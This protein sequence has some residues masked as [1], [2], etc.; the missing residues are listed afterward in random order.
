MHA[1]EAAIEWL[2]DG[3]SADV[4]GRRFSGRTTFMRGIRSQLED[5]GWR[6]LWVS[7]NAF[8]QNSPL[9]SLELSGVITGT[10]RGRSALHSAVAG[11][12]G[13]ARPE[14]FVVL[15]DDWDSLDDASWGVLTAAQEQVGFPIVR[16]TLRR[17][18]LASS[19]TGIHFEQSPRTFVVDLRPMTIDELERVLVTH[20]E[21]PIDNATASRIL[22]K[23][24]GVVGLAL[25]IVD[26]ARAEGTLRQ[27]AGLW[28]AEA[29]LWSDS[30]T[31]IAE[32]YIAGISEAEL[33]VLET[34]ALVGE[35]DVAEARATL[36]WRAVES[37]ED[38]AL[39]RLYSIGSR[40]LVSVVP[41]LVMELLRNQTHCARRD[42]V[43]QDILKDGILDGGTGTERSMAGRTQG[44]EQPDALFVR[45]FDEHARGRRTT[46]RARWLADP[47]PATAVPFLQVLNDQ[48]ADPDE[49][50]L[51]FAGTD[52]AD[53]DDESRAQFAIQRAW[54]TAGIDGDLDAALTELASARGGLGRY[55]RLVDAARVDIES[56][57]RGI[58][59]DAESLLAIDDDA[60][61][62]PS[63]RDKISESRLATFFSLGQFEKARTA[64]QFLS[65]TPLGGSVY[66]PGFL[67]G[68]LALFD[69]E[70]DA[71][72]ES[73]ILAFHR[74]R[75]SLDAARLRSYGY[76]CAL[77]LMLSGRRNDAQPYIDVVLALGRPPHIPQIVQ[78]GIANVGMLLAFR[79]GDADGAAVIESQRRDLPFTDAGTLPLGS[80]P[81]AQRSVVAGNVLA[82]SDALWAS[83]LGQWERGARVGGLLSMFAALEL[84]YSEQRA[85]R[86]TEFVGQ[87]DS[88]FFAV[89]LEVVRA[90]AAKSPERLRDAARRLQELGV[91]GRAIT[92]LR[93]ALKARTGSRSRDLDADLER[94]ADELGIDV[95]ASDPFD[96][97]S[98]IPKLS[99]RE[100]EVAQRA[101]EGMSNQE[102]A[103]EL[104]LSVRTV[105]NHVHRIMRK[106]GI[107]SRTGLAE[108]M[109][110]A[111]GT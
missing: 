75:G 27:T 88:E 1:L 11:V 43:L 32:A 24:G 105:E 42:R 71:G 8:L 77:G 31:R 94:A 91:A 29:G 45:S 65:E 38:R 53:G 68:M 79:R 35:L 15:V 66:S 39:I 14:R 16:A 55:G 59:D 87:V 41:P 81:D 20:L 73:S 89:Q 54:W 40:R 106:T 62:P 93:K 101:A 90:E 19:P 25:N 18:A 58:P 104:L 6:T 49:I 56:A 60:E 52:A 2:R 7:G 67:A 108:F 111:S 107:E 9:S 69:G 33:D 84:E 86:L 99:K 3:A 70:L 80:W 34:L 103:D 64:L 61:L 96:F 44:W 30:L 110:A 12:E 17:R 5:E 37:L 47:S 92:A 74:A 50:E 109:K 26:A 102:I 76:L 98:V 10:S 63:V 51:V 95:T 21:G 57:F 23:S 28:R 4:I 85:A 13:L 22:A 78:L 72:L 48:H 46:T 100:I 82:S 36:D 83:G 97:L